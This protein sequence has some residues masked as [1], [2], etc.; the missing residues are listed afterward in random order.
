MATIV[1]QIRLNASGTGLLLDDGQSNGADITT[2]VNNGDIVKWKLIP[3]SGITSIDNIVDTS[4]D[5]F[6][7]DP[8]PQPGGFWQG[9]VSASAGSSETYC[10][11]FTAAGVSYTHDP[12]IQVNS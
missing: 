7:P 3:N 9:T 10:I 2:N 8:A 5:V 6:S 4:T 11:Y 12:K 1:I